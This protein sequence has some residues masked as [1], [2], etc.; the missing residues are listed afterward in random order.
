MKQLYQDRIFAIANDPNGMITVDGSGF[1]KKGTKS[2][3]VHR[4]Y[5]GSK[6]KIENCQAGVFIGYSGAKGYGLLDSRLYLPQVW[7]DN[8]HRADWPKCDI[9]ATTEFRTKLQL[10]LEMIQQAV[11]NQVFQFNWKSGINFKK[12][13]NGDRILV[14]T[15]PQA[16]ILIIAAITQEPS[17]IKKALRKVTYYQKSNTNAYRSHRKKRLKNTA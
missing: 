16:L 13:E 1:A 8:E 11:K 9:P 5:C 12:N 10:A 15:M 17:V 14:L 4:Q 6:G 7:F 3:G 2:A